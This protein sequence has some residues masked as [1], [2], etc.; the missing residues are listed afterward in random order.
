LEIFHGREAILFQAPAGE[1]LLALHGLDGRLVAV[2]QGNAGS[3]PRHRLPPGTYLVRLA[4][5]DGVRMARVA[6]TSR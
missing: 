2:F 1:R 6:V 5:R 4:G 3:V